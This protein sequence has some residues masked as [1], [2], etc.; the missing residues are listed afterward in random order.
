MED[1]QREVLEIEFNE[2][3]KGMNRISPIEF[4]EILLR[5]TDFNQEKKKRL[6]RKLNTKMEAFSREITFDKFLDFSKFMMNLKDFQLALQFHMQAN[7]SIS[8]KE[9]QR[10]VKISSGFEL[11]PKI[12]EVIYKVFDENNDGQLSYKE[13]IAVLK[14]RLK[15]GLKTT[16]KHIYEMST[17]SQSD[18]FSDANINS[19]SDLMRVNEEPDSFMK[20]FKKCIRQKLRERNYD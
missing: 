20:K 3:S 8:Q 14:D 13:F 5:Y 17:F 4:A 7:R 9:F 10:A 16:K 12:V 19:Q 15:R 6:I 2:F 18:L 11:D 1:L